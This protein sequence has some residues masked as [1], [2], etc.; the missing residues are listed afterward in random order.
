MV[1]VRFINYRPQKWHYFL[2]DFC[3]YGTSISLLFV[4]VFPKNEILYRCAFLY[5]AGV[6]A[7]ATAAFENALIFHKFDRL[8]CL[9]THPVPMVCLWN[10]RHVTMEHEKTLPDKDARFLRHPEDESLWSYDAFVMN[11]VYPYALY[12]V[13]AILYYLFNFVL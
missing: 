2:L 3:Y 4:I 12:F 5:S 8:I 11:F 10:V 1:L 9:V 13:W 7:L 6:N